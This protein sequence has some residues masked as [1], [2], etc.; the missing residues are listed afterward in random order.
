VHADDDGRGATPLDG[1]GDVLSDAVERVEPPTLDLERQDLQV[2]AR[3]ILGE[4]PAPGGLM[5]RV[6]ADLLDDRSGHVRRPAPEQHREEW[7]RHLRVAR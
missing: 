2:H 6:G 4:R 7:H 3:E 5:A 1:L